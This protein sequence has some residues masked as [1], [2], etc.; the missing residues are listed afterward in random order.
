MKREQKP[1]CSGLKRGGEK[2]VRD[3]LINSFMEFGQKEEEKK[4]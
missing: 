3:N 2:M 1:V 4:M